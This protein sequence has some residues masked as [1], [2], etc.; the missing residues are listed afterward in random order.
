MKKMSH[1]FTK[2]SNILLALVFLLPC[3]LW[4]GVSEVKPFVP[5]SLEEILKSRQGEPFMLVLWSKDCSSCLK[6]MHV[7]AE[8]HKKYPGLDMVMLATDGA[9]HAEQLI[10][11]LKKHDLGDIET[12]AFSEAQAQRL[13]YEIDP[14]WYGELPRTYFYESSHHRIGRSGT[15][16]LQQ[17]GAWVAAVAQ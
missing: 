5:G 13:R 8:I 2:V 16:E 10:S 7:L 17:V 12:W 6:E 4:A 3:V 15:L 14:A 11:I 9:E 1:Q